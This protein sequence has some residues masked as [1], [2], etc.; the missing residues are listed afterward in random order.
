M[1]RKYKRIA[2][3][4]ASALGKALKSCRTNRQI[5]LKVASENCKVDYGQLSRFEAGK[6]KVASD[7]LQKYA[8]FLQISINEI[9]EDPSLQDASITNRVSAFIS[10]STQNRIVIDRILSALENIKSP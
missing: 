9:V 7:N 3:N 1:N 5:T 8:E 2:I 4:E 6:F 10:R